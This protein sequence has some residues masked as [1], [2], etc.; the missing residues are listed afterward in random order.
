MS[1]SLDNL[2]PPWILTIVGK[3]LSNYVLD[4]TEDGFEVED[5]G[6]RLIFTIA[7]D[8]PTAVIL[9]WQAR[10]TDAFVSL[11]DS[12]CQI[13]AILMFSPEALA[14]LRDSIDSSK[15]PNCPQ[16]HMITLLDFKFVFTYS[17]PAVQL[18]LVVNHCRIHFDDGPAKFTPSKKIKKIHFKDLDQAKQK[19]LQSRPPV[20]SNIAMTPTCKSVSHEINQ[21]FQSQSEQPSGVQSQQLVTQIISHDHDVLKSGSEVALSRSRGADLL[22]NLTSNW[23][24]SSRNSSEEKSQVSSPRIL[25][26]DD[27]GSTKRTRIKEPTETAPLSPFR[28]GHM[29]RRI[30]IE[31]QFGTESPVRK[32]P[33]THKLSKKRRLEVTE[34]AA[35]EVA[36]L[37]E[38]IP[39]KKRQRTDIIQEELEE[40]LET[41]LPINQPGMPSS[42]NTLF[43]PERD[44]TPVNV[45]DPKFGDP[46]EGLVSISSHDITIPKDQD[47]LLN[48][49]ICWIP[50]KTGD[51][52][53]QAHVPPSLLQI[54][55]NIAA[56]SL[57]STEQDRAASVDRPVTPTQDT[58]SSAAS[59]A[60][61]WSPS[62]LSH[63][64]RPNLPADSSPVA[65][66]RPSEILAIP[67]GNEESEDIHGSQISSQADRNE[68]YWPQSTTKS[69]VTEKSLSPRKFFKTVHEGMLPPATR[70]SPAHSEKSDGQVY[71]QASSQ[72]ESQVLIPSPLLPEESSIS[73]HPIQSTA[74]E[75]TDSDDESMMDVSVPLGLGEAWPCPTQSSQAEPELASSALFVSSAHVEHVQ[76]AETP[77]VGHQKLSKNQTEPEPFNSILSS[78]QAHNRS[79]QSRVLNTYHS[80]QKYQSSAQDSELSKKT[81]DDT[82]LVHVP[83]TQVEASSMNQEFQS[84]SQNVSSEIVP[85]SSE[86]H[87]NLPLS[88]S[89]L[90]EPLSPNFP[91][92][93]EPAPSQ[94]NPS[95]QD[96]AMKVTPVHGWTPINGPTELPRAFPLGPLASA[97]QDQSPSKNPRSP[98]RARKIVKKSLP[99]TTQNNV[100][101]ELRQEYV[102]S[103]AT[104]EDAQEVYRHFCSEYTNYSGDFGH[105]S[106]VCAKLKA[107]QVQGKLQRPYL[108]D[109][110][111]IMHFEEY[112]EYIHECTLQER[113]TLSY[114]EYFMNK[115]SKANYKKR[116]LTA[117]RIDL[118]AC[119]FM[120]TD[121]PPQS[122][123]RSADCNLPAVVENIPSV[124]GQDIDTSFTA[125]L[126]NQFSKFHTHSFENNGLGLHA[127]PSGTPVLASASLFSSPLIK[128]EGSGPHYKDAIGAQLPE[129]YEDQMIICNAEN[130]ANG[131]IRD[132]DNVVTTEDRGEERN[133]EE[134][135]E[136][137][138]EKP[139]KEM[140]DFEVETFKERPED[141]EIGE[142]QEEEKEPDIMTEKGEES[143]AVGKADTDSDTFENESSDENAVVTDTEE[144]AETNTEEI[145]ETDT[146]DR[147]RE[148]SVELGDDTFISSRQQSRR[149]ATPG[150]S[151]AEFDTESDV[152][153]NHESESECEE[154]NWFHYLLRQRRSEPVWSDDPNTP[155]KQWAVADQN[156]FSERR[157]RG[158]F[159]ILVD[160]QGVIQRPINR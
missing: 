157:R 27:V 127:G 67:A 96:T 57:R 142:T 148:T 13:D 2:F 39:S 46:W 5:D 38:D 77:T 92:S 59:E 155:F 93:H 95:S 86:G 158:G 123:S 63:F 107:L 89:H 54:W 139:D 73:T 145:A 69:L 115:F 1:H 34:S 23:N 150:Q 134:E 141:L 129:P 40:Q 37:S 44:I 28:S 35:K 42:S 15:I 12:K 88:N 29:D 98:K 61:N 84:Q 113:K 14:T 50:P 154:E 85:D 120:P 116:F 18:H 130:G 128:A 6:S 140:A 104:P 90:V 7:C 22:R 100:S 71:G 81:R 106:E 36:E 79:S 58:V 118:V 114:E 72:L 20:K 125:S 87:E 121:M 33:G 97:D 160:E 102:G 80:H 62:P 126:T 110:F 117:D 32:D 74:N 153:S 51:L 94:Q 124:E 43:D 24:K 146:E 111:A 47:E 49:N 135:E 82:P 16:K 60:S 52:M 65:P 137:E 156:V 19:A 45:D 41:Q 17:T 91:S 108:W 4:K 26:L 133:N 8:A 101:V 68:N 143:A 76:V 31:S 25:P 70:A 56:R 152:E 53:P 21:S 3:C 136:G 149:E 109:D 64:R 75:E 138:K 55:N 10:V 132:T 119:K 159:N 83:G 105:F 48:N 151:S 78:S 144:I 112:P 122:T 11:M 131:E 147:H 30:S 66:R 103:Q 99:T 9:Q